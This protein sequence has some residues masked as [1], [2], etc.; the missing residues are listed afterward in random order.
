MSEE[1]GGEIV[2]D[3]T[4]DLDIDGEVDLMI[5]DLDLWYANKQ[6]LYGVSLPIA[7]NSVTALIGPSG[8]GKSTLLRTINR[9]NDLIPICHYEGKISKGEVE[10]TAKDA[11]LVEIRRN[12]GMVFQRPNPFPKSIYDNV[13]YGVR[14]H[15]QPTREELDNIVEK[16]LS[17]AAIWSEVAD[18][19]HDLGTSLSGGQ[20]QRL[21]I[22][23]TIAIEP[24]VI[25]MD[26]PCSALDPIATAAIEELILEL[27]KD[28]TVVIVTHSMSQAARVSDY[29]GFMYLGRM[30][31]FNKTE[32][33]FSDPDQELTKDTSQE[34]LDEV[35]LCQ[36]EQDLMKESPRYKKN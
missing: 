34:D 21:C 16:S 2:P 26:E 17:R 32:K 18:R 10:I 23:R 1:I 14:L 27:K 6:A 28:F 36:L 5:E 33:I 20:Q 31:E 22:A 19:L 35:E 3:S 11:D 4:R 25:L 15:H 30:V 13:A 29:T 24:D 8:C 9:M 7:K 12:I